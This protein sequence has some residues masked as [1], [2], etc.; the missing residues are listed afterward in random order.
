MSERASE[1]DISDYPVRIL[2]AGSRNYHD[3]AFFD[4]EMHR[5]VE[6]LCNSY[7]RHLICFISGKA[8]YGPDDM[9]IFWCEQNGYKCFEYPADW[10]KYG[11]KIAGF[12]RNAEMGKLATH[13][14][15]FWDRVSGGTKDMRDIVMARGI[16]RVVYNVKRA[17]ERSR[18]Y[19]ENKL[20]LKQ[21][22]TERKPRQSFCR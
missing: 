19:R 1:R 13:A 8:R 4:A 3:Y 11:P 5:R 10:D 14:I 18:H 15:L 22:E 2:V 21:S 16:H 7:P 12:I 9:I 20:W 17:D 6:I